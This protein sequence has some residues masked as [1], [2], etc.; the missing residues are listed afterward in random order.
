LDG[1]D[2]DERRAAH[3]SAEPWVLPGDLALP[4]E[5]RAIV[6]RCLAKDAGERF[7]SC[8]ELISA[9]DLFENAA[10]QTLRLPKIEARAQRGFFPGPDD[11]FADKFRVEAAIGRGGFS[12][13]FKALTIDGD[14]PVAL[15]ILRPDRKADEIAVRRFVREGKLIFTLLSSPH[16]IS[17]FDYGETSDGLL[18]IAFEYITGQTLDQIVYK[19]G[20]LSPQRVTRVLE[21]CLV[22]ISE[23][24]AM[25]ILHRDIKPSNIMLSLRN[26]VQ[27]WV[28]VLDFG[29]AKITSDVIDTTDLTATGAALGTPRYM[30]PE[31]IAGEPLDPAS[32]LYSLGLVAYELLVGEKAIQGSNTLEIIANQLDPQSMIVPSSANVPAPLTMIVNRMMRKDRHTRYSSAGELLMALRELD[33]EVGETTIDT[34]TR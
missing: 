22:S 12:R 17:V 5:F 20:K 4:A 24:H 18:Y 21:Q 15:K 31:Q 7:A 1:A 29:V 2:E 30:S 33:R 26:G 19:E 6:E 23:A 3:L 28:T 16:T 8:S 9:L 14:R 11:V 10:A 34:G 32:D 27:D 25:G 13:V